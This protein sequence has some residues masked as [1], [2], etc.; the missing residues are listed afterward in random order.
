LIPIVADASALLPA[1]LPAERYQAHADRLIDLHAK[2]KIQLC[3]PSLLPQEILNGLYLAVRGKAG[4]PS[5]LTREGVGERW[6]LFQ[7][8]QIQIRDI[9]DLA[10][11]ILELSLTY[12]RPSIYDMA[13]IALAESLGAV[14]VT[15]DERLLNAVGKELAW[16][17]APWEFK[18][19]GP[20]R[21]RL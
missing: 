10:E 9:A 19:L 8:L 4:S 21:S 11:R 6:K 14:M 16:V 2:G 15:A 17:Q 13:Y 5:R 1:W 3:G 12:K 18:L 7:Q 20:G